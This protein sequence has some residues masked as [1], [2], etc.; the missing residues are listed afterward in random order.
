SVPWPAGRAFRERSLSGSRHRAEG[1]EGNR[2]IRRSL[3]HGIEVFRQDVRARN[4]LLR[5]LRLLRILSLP[6][7]VR[8]GTARTARL[9][10]HAD[11]AEREVAH[12]RRQA[13]A[14]GHRHAERTGDDT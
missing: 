14:A 13:A 11:A 3:R 12:P 7:A 9:P 8:T 4:M 6:H 10:G 1:Y 5:I 2:R